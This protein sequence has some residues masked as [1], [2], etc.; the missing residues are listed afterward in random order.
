MVESDFGMVDTSYSEPFD[1]SG[2]DASVFDS[3]IAELNLDTALDGQQAN[4]A[5][6]TTVAAAAQSLQIGGVDLFLSDRQTMDDSLSPKRFTADSSLGLL[7]GQK[8]DAGNSDKGWWGATWDKAD[9]Y[10]KQALVLTLVGAVGSG[11][12]A[13]MKGASDERVVDKQIESNQTLLQQKYDLEKQKVAENQPGRIERTKA[14][15]LLTP[16]SWKVDPLKMTQDNINSRP[17]GVANAR[18]A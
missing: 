15:T 11:V 7:G 12:G 3:V 6:T 17:K 5:I 14:T 13:V 2:W 1:T 8:S 9:P 4:E 10:M 18:T 16:E